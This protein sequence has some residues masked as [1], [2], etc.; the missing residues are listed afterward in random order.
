MEALILLLDGYVD[1]DFI[2]EGFSKGFFIYFDGEECDTMAQ[3]NL[4]FKENLKV[5]MEKI[6]EEIQLGRIKGPFKEKPFD[7]FKI[8]PLALREKSTPGTYRLLHNLS[9]P[10]DLRAVNVG[11]PQR[12]KSVKYSTIL[13][14]V[15]IIYRY[16]GSFMAKTDIQ[17]AFR[18]V[19]ISP[20]SYHLMGFQVNGFFYYDCC[21]AMG[22]SQSCS[23]FER[24]S[25]SL[26]WIMKVHYKIENIVKVL[27]DFIFIEKTALKCQNSLE[28]FIRVCN[29][30]RIPLAMN[31]T[32]WPAQSI[33]FL[34]LLI[35]SQK[36]IVQ[37]PHDKLAR[38]SEEISKS[39]GQKTIKLRDLK[40]II[41]KLT[42]ATSVVTG[43]RCFLRRLHD[44][45]KG[46]LEL[47]KSIPVSNDIKL[48]LQV[49]ESFMVS[50]NGKHVI[51]MLGNLDFK[52]TVQTD[53]SPIGY[54]AIIGT[55]YFYGAFPGKWQKLPIHLLEFYPILITFL[56]CQEMF[57]GEAVEIFTDNMVVMY[58]INNLT[59][60]DVTLMG[61]IRRFVRVLLDFNIQVRA[62]YISTKDNY[63]ADSL[64]RLQVQPEHLYQLGLDPN[65]HWL[66][67]AHL[68]PNNF[69]FP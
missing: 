8:S 19:P 53:A 64:S 31:K 49:W 41:G 68:R 61:V 37:L 29:F 65:Q 15:D 63:V 40:S 44:A 11:I 60:S 54:G 35:D 10:Y 34:G 28:I 57:R 66:V 12:F 14:A 58:A 16:P 46:V 50:Y 30:L 38:Y 22:C 7:K 25:D 2:I 62:T 45:T 32:T 69:P 48:D 39:L 59:C 56:M 55:K 51:T 23:I 18:I 26:V 21:L 33:I 43:G 47:D 20:E 4:S 1:R 6:N 17:S 24:I 52:F 3:N 9:H 27:D 36:M 13:D 42:F 67:P 5:G